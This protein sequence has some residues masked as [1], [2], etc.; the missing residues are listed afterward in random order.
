M[1]FLGL[2][3]WE[4][5][6]RRVTEGAGSRV[7]LGWVSWLFGAGIVL[8]HP[9]WQCRVCPSKQV[10]AIKVKVFRGS[11]IPSFL[12]KRGVKPSNLAVAGI[13]SQLRGV[14]DP[15]GSAIQ[16]GCLSSEPLTRFHKLG[17]WMM[18]LSWGLAQSLRPTVHPALPADP[19]RVRTAS[20]RCWRCG[21][22]A[23]PMHPNIAPT[24]AC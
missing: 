12:H 9:T 23:H 11:I 4:S 21:R 24:C 22:A 15:S 6:L 3:V 8:Q 17:N 10:S 19:S 13:V 7:G 14:A 5:R 1:G 2:R 20:K 16:P 18:Q